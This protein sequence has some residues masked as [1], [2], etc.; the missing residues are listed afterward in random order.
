MAIASALLGGIGALVGGSGG[1]SASQHMAEDWSNSTSDSWSAGGS[2]SLAFTDAATA[3]ANAHNEAAINR[4]F[5]EYMSNT[6]YQR[7]VQDLKYA[8][9]NPILATGAQASTPAG[10]TA[11]SFMNSYSSGSSFESSGSHSES[12]SYGYSKSRSQSLSAVRSL[13]QDIGNMAN[14]AISIAQQGAEA[15]IYALN[16]KYY[17]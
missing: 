4:A 13:F 6:A 1:N 17:H 12:D 15:N 14:S 9:L 11:Q 3:N 16:A 7:A 5:Q 8:G 10:A 2:Q